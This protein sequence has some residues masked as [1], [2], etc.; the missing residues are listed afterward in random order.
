[1]KKEA[2]K[3]SAGGKI[4]SIIFL[5]LSI[6]L[7]IF[8]IIIGIMAI[9]YKKYLFALLFVFLGLFTFLPRKVIKIANWKKFLI[10]LG[11]FILLSTMSVFSN[12][13]WNNDN[14]VDHNMQEKF[15]LDTG[16]QNISMIIYNA[17]KEESILVSGQEKT[18]T[19]YFLVINCEIT[20]L[21]ESPVLVSP[22]YD[23]IDNQNQT[24]GGIGF[25]GSQ[26]YFQP[27]L[28]KQCY[29][30]FELPDSA[31]GMKFRIKDNSAIHVIDLEM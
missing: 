5:I 26:E 9:F 16:T 1:M 29:F 25:S 10:G 23:I 28:R 2:E 19:G 22:G 18:T 17:T 7:G 4:F 21:G 14:F 20:N 13:N 31:Q 3:Q 27:D 6:I 12:W 11:V 15:T 30:V 8:A 24:Y